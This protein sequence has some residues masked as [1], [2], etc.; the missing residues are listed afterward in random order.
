M[1]IILT[2]RKPAGLICQTLYDSLRAEVKAGRFD[3]AFLLLQ[4]LE[5][6]YKYPRGPFMPVHNGHA[7]EAVQLLAT[8]RRIGQEPR[9]QFGQEQPVHEQQFVCEG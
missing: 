9:R 1:T 8:V 4:E 2:A 6:R 7:R 3:N 5:K